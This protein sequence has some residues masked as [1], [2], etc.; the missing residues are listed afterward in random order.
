M[1]DLLHVLKINLLHMVDV[2]KL[3]SKEDFPEKLK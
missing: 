3:N 2:C 1:L